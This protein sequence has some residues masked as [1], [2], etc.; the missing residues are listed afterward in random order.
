M[1][2]IELLIRFFINFDKLLCKI[3]TFAFDFF[4]DFIISGKLEYGDVK[5]ITLF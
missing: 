2:V 3:N 5:R 4:N 1:N